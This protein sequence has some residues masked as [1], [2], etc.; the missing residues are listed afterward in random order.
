MMK[1]PL[2]AVGAVLCIAAGGVAGAAH[3]S[4]TPIL[5]SVAADGSDFL[6]SYHV[7]LTGDEGI[8]P[9]SKLVI[10]DFAGYVPGSVFSPTADI[11]ANAEL[12]SNTNWPG[13]AVK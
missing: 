9:G 3:A 2:L 8:K 1:R 6:Y 11:T 4:I 12:L 5:D 13:S 10:F 7:T